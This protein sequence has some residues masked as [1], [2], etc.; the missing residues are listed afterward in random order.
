MH[1]LLIR[2][3]LDAMHCEKNLCE[4]M[5]KTT[6]GSKDS[7]GNRQDLEKQGIWEEMWLRPARNNKEIFH[8][9]HVPYVLKPMEKMTVMSIIKNLK[10]PLNYVGAIQKCLE[11]GKLQY[12]K[13]HDFHV[14][15]QQVHST[16][17][18]CQHFYTY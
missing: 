7:Y 12:M 18:L 5:L 3:L 16:F 13:S 4:N 10:T 1:K 2:H 9:P 11:D 15:M 17:L 8:M 14:V 6:F